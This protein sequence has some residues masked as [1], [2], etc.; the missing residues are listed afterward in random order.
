M[1]E[2]VKLSSLPIGC[3]GHVLRV[4]MGGD[5]RRHIMDLGFTPGATV[6]KLYS[7]WA[8]SPAAYRVRGTTVA[9]R[10]GDADRILVGRRGAAESG[11]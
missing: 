7:A 8:G 11:D 9:L 2:T 6:E 4:S 10:T 1:E 3:P 5:V